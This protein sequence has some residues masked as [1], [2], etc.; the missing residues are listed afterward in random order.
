MRRALAIDEQSYGTEHPDV[1]IDLNNLAAL[2]QATNRLGEAE[3]LMRRALAI[4]EQ[5]Y[6]TEHPNVAIDLNNL[7]A[8]LQATNRLGEAEPLMRRSIT[9][10][11][12]FQ[13][14]TGH[15]HP[16]LRPVL[17]N[18]LNLLAAMGLSPEEA[19]SSVEG[20]LRGDG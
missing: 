19:R 4:D 2:L 9:I 15:L 6:G 7:A 18:Y 10:L 20:I 3:P 1:A 16:H 17:A 12:A 8:L 13:H 14:A 5:S 11:V